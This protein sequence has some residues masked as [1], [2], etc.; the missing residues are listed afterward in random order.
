MEKGPKAVRA[1]VYTRVS[2]GQQA[3][4]GLGLTDQLDRATAAVAERGWTLVHVATDAGHSGKR[5]SGRPALTEALSMLDRGEAD[6]L[7]TL[8]L[9]RLSRSVQDFASLLSQAQ[10]KG[11][12]VVALDVGVDTSTPAGKMVANVMAA[13]SQWESEVIGERTAAAHR[14]RRDAGTSVGQVPILSAAI[15]ERIVAEMGKG[16]SLRS[17][18]QELNAEEVP[19]AK[20]GA[21]YASTVAHVGRSVAR[22]ANLAAKRASVA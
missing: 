17:I 21:W 15:R 12:Q 10:R 9:D 4:S 14:V 11:W 20:G 6:A 2:T 3:E 8:K 7:V 19:T 13:V 22:E 5:L 16:R 18:A 1:I